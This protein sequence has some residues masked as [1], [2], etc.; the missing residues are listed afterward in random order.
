MQ[1]Q[2]DYLGFALFN[3]RQEMRT[4]PFLINIS[5]F[6]FNKFLS[7]ASNLTSGDIYNGYKIVPAM[8]D[9]RGENGITSIYRRINLDCDFL[10]HC[11]FR[12]NNNFIH[13]INLTPNNF[14][15]FFGRFSPYNHFEHDLYLVSATLRMLEF[16]PFDYHHQIGVDIEVYYRW[17]ESL[18]SF[19]KILHLRLHQEPKI[20]WLP[21]EPSTPR[22]EWRSL[23]NDVLDHRMR[24]INRLEFRS[25]FNSLFL[26]TF[27][28]TLVGTRLRDR[29]RNGLGVRATNVITPRKIFTN[30]LQLKLDRFD[31]P[32]HIV[33]LFLGPV[34]YYNR[35]FSDQRILVQY[36]WTGDCL[37]LDM[38]IG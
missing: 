34:L 2:Y 31:S 25:S 28:E 30:G 20:P 15:S 8:C 7:S 37:E 10:Y 29:F 23:G 11:I 12:D 22:S 35:D 3:K 19:R 27:P 36:R 1:N 9:F 24:L 16:N 13:R 17:E 32:R 14:A 6:H 4:K 38:R 5:P 21:I 26:V 18:T 33:K